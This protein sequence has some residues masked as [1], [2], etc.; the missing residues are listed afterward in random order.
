MQIELTELRRKAESSKKLI[1]SLGKLKLS[2]ERKLKRSNEEREELA[3]ENMELHIS[4]HTIQ[5]QLNKFGDLKTQVEATQE[6][7]AVLV[8]TVVTKTEENEDL[9]QKIKELED[10]LEVTKFQVRL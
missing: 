7:N 5:G 4:K 2:L 9:Q 3:R 1:K 10:E 6:N 8:Q